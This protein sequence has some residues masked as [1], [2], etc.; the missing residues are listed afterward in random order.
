MISSPQKPTLP[1]ELFSQCSVRL[2][3]Y[4]NTCP[5][6]KT[7]LVYMLFQFVHLRRCVSFI[8]SFYGMMQLHVKCGM[9]VF[10]VEMYIFEHKAIYP[11]HV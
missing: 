7:E 4:R 8:V 10:L 9:D 5:T 2:T 6:W 1:V 11:F 3:I